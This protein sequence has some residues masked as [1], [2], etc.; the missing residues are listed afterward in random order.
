M[1]GFFGLPNRIV[2]ETTES[3]SIYVET[4]GNDNTGLGTQAAPYLTLAKALDSLPE[5]INHDC[6]IYMGSGTFGTAATAR[7]TTTVSDTVV[8]SKYLFIKGTV[9]ELLAEQTAEGGTRSTITDTGAFT[10]QDYSGKFVELLAGPNYIDTGT[11]YWFTNY[12][13]IRSN[14]DDVLTLG[15]KLVSALTAATH[16]RIVE[17]ATNFTGD[18]TTSHYNFTNYSSLGLDIHLQNINFSKSYYGVN[19]YGK[20]WVQ[21]CKFTYDTTGYS[22]MYNNADG[23]MIG[24]GNYFTGTFINAAEAN[25][26][27]A[28]CSA[29]YSYFYNGKSA[30]ENDS[31]NYFFDYGNVIDTMTQYGIKAVNSG[32][33]KGSDNANVGSEYSN[34]T[35]QAFYAVVGGKISNHNATGSGNG[36]IGRVIG[37]SYILYDSSKLT[38]TGTAHTFDD[39]AGTIVDQ[40]TGAAYT[41]NYNLTT[42]GNLQTLNGIIRNVTTVNAATYD[43]LATDDIVHVTYTGTGAVTSLTL[44]TAQVTAGRTI[45]IK[46]AGGNASVNNITVDTEGAE[47]IDG[48][49]TFVMTSDYEDISLYSDGSNWFIISQ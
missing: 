17:N 15:C 1:S 8:T 25:N 20:C 10:G 21:G 23:Y 41:L 6:Y 34:C 33:I 11:Y 24:D 35:L 28:Y 27:G 49:A 22:G 29:R 4:T 40:D 32:I 26:F 2:K 5:A 36:G 31:G 45:V 42:D 3:L 18:G 12:Y 30:I 37:S 47:T 38:A 39:A 14:T 44:P 46:D 7:K 9:T 19:N 48:A 43:L 13:P 16:Y